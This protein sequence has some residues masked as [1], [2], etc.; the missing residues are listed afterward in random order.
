[1]KVIT[2]CLFTLIVFTCTVES[3]NDL[4]QNNPY[5]FS[6]VVVVIDSQGV[7]LAQGSGIIFN[8]ADGLIAVT[9]HAIEYGEKNNRTFKVQ[10]DEDEYTASPLWKN[11]V[12]DIGILK[13]DSIDAVFLTEAPSS[14]NLP[15][16]GDSVTLVGFPTLSDPLQS[17][18][19]LIKKIK[20]YRICQQE[21]PLTVVLAVAPTKKSLKPRKVAPS[22][23]YVFYSS[24]LIAKPNTYFKGEVSGFSGGFLSDNQGVV[25]AIFYGYKHIGQRFYFVPLAEIPEK[26]WP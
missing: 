24:H 23:E 20:T 25:K 21:I 17:D 11:R 13:L 6:V 14:I 5:P 15:S 9:G 16:I 8:K 7:S 3:Q 4:L 18:Y 22:E 26:Y 12:R 10:I 1:M 2:A 19:C